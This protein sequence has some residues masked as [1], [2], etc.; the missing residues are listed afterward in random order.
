MKT[1]RKLLVAFFDGCSFICHKAE[2]FFTALAAGVFDL[3]DW[4]DTEKE[5]WDQD[6]LYLL[7]ELPI[8][9]SGLMAWEIP[10][11]KYMK[12]GGTVGVIGCGAG[13]DMIA[14]AKEGFVVEGVDISDRAINAAK[15]FLADAGIEGKV[16]VG[17]C[18]G[19]NGYFQH[20]SLAKKS[21]MKPGMLDL[22]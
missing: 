13:R 3:A 5:V 10:I 6:T 9:L 18:F 15:K 8:V 11:L 2:C 21:K 4:K 17:D 16:Y 19:R 22:K 12:P 7:Q 1:I 20:F 14:F